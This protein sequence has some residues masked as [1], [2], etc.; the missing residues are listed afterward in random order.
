[1]NRSMSD[2]AAQ[3]IDFLRNETDPQETE[4][5]LQ[6]I[7]QDGQLKQLGDEVRKC[8]SALDLAGSVQPPA[9]LAERTMSR[10]GQRREVERLITRE[11]SRRPVVIRPAFSWREMAAVAAALILAAAVVVPSLQ[12]S[13]QEAGL[14]QC[15]TNI[16]QLGRAMLGFADLHEGRLPGVCSESDRWL[17]ADG[18]PA[19]SNSA[20]LFKLV[21][22]GLVKPEMFKCAGVG[23]KAMNSAEAGLVDFPAAAYVDYSYQHSIGSCGLTSWRV[24]QEPDSMVILADATPLFGDGQFMPKRLGCSGSYNHGQRGQNVL[25]VNGAV[26]WAEAPTVGVNNDDIYL[27][28]G[29]YNY[30]GIERPRNATDT[31]LLPNSIKD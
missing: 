13:R 17:P 21:R 5:I 2:D 31:F 4:R 18:Q 8:F 12:K 19:V 26:L 7:G 3:L 14:A 16:G 24:E 29:L 20:A 27:A 1:M 6:R 25:Y 10:I 23:G 11:E 30:R 9:D 15:A 22:A 28:D